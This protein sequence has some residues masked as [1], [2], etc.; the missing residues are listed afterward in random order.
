MWLLSWV[1]TLFRQVLDLGIEVVAASQARPVLLAAREDGVG[2]SSAD[3]MG[4]MKEEEEGHLGCGL[5]TF[6][7][8]LLCA[9]DCAGCCGAHTATGKTCKMY[10]SRV[11]GNL[12]SHVGLGLSVGWSDHLE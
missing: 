1:G 8:L 10:V 5:G 4:G 7:G 9:V 11:H 2:R 6:I 3:L 12:V